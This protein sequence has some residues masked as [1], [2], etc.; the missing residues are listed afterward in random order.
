MKIKVH[1]EDGIL[2]P[3]DEYHSSRTGNWLVREPN[4]SVRAAKLGLATLFVSLYYLG[5][6]YVNL[7]V[8]NIFI[9]YIL[10]FLMRYLI[11]VQRQSTIRL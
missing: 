11:S 2:E 8:S 1:L 9:I 7:D 6:S 5:I 4:F 3:V 10:G